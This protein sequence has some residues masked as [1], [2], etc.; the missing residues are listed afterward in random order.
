MGSKTFSRRSRNGSYKFVNIMSWFSF[1]FKTPQDWL[2]NGRKQFRAKRY[3]DAIKSYDKALSMDPKFSDAWYEKGRCLLASKGNSE[4][5]AAFDSALAID[6]KNVYVLLEKGYLLKKMG[7]KDESLKVFDY[8]LS[9]DPENF[10]AKRAQKLVTVFDEKSICKE[11]G[12]KLFHQNTCPLCQKTLC[13][14]CLDSRFHNCIKDSIPKE[15]N[16][17]RVS[18]NYS[19]NGHIE[20]RK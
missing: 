20:A 15:G 8:I 17:P 2:E 9:F 13:W 14:E 5:I 3:T 11:C 12:I 4:A 16:V 10:V 6:S 7:K 18:I 19:A 1:L